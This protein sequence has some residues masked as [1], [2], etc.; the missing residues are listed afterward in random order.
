MYIF[1][2]WFHNNYERTINFFIFDNK[3]ILSLQSCTILECPTTLRIYWYSQWQVYGVITSP[4]FPLDNTVFDWF[5]MVLVFLLTLLGL[6]NL[7]I[8]NYRH[9]TLNISTVLSPSHPSH[10]FIDTVCLTVSTTH[11][12]IPM[13]IGSSK[14]CT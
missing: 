2:F 1:H 4:P 13:K 9:R 8:L 10:L 14:K 3:Y 6:C 5:S 12:Q 11:K 7:V